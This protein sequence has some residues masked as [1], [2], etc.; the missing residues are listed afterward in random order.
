MRQFLKVCVLLV[1]GISCKKKTDSPS[2]DKPLFE[3]DIN[4]IHW[5]ADSVFAIRL[6]VNAPPLAGYFSIEAKKNDS[7]YIFLHSENDTVSAITFKQTLASFTAKVDV[8][9]S[10]Y[11]T[12]NFQTINEDQ[13][14]FIQVERSYDGADF[15]NIETISAHGTGNHSYTFSEKPILT[16]PFA[17]KVYY[18]LKFLDADNSFVYSNVLVVSF[19]S[20]ALYIFSS[21]DYALGYNGNINITSTDKIKQI[22]SGDFYFSYTIDVTH[23]HIKITNG[24]FQNIPYR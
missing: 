19:G 6:S 8:P 21:Q 4:G 7:S 15:I 24:K 18:R 20:P 9:D 14:S 11:I 1:I 13:T 2:P 23:E 16:D 5:Q 10:N 22:I 12:L 17:T 3:A